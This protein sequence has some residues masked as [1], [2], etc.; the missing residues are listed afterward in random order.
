MNLN[1][2]SFQ[3][4]DRSISMMNKQIKNIPESLKH[5]KAW[6]LHRRGFLKWMIGTTGAL[7]IPWWLS[8]QHKSKKEEGF[9]LNQEQRNILSFVQSFLFPSDGN[10]P[11]ATELNA[12]DYVQW[13]LS[14]SYMDVEE[15]QYLFKGISWVEETAQEESNSSFLMLD[16]PHKIALLDQIAEEDWGE[17]WYSMNLT[18]VFEALLSDPIYGANKEGIGWAWLEHNPGQPRPSAA[19]KY[20]Q[21]LSYIDQQK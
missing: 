6:S 17:A 1:F 7:S 12:I 9:L 4:Y 8:C 20:G 15:K 16:T 2:V 19:M 5:P 21:F 13:V 11:G 3:H 10:G 14:D 18:F